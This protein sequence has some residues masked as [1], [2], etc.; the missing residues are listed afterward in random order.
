M[1]SRVDEKVNIKSMNQRKKNGFGLYGMVSWFLA[2]SKKGNRLG[3]LRNKVDKEAKRYDSKTKTFLGTTGEEMVSEKD[4]VL[5]TNA[6]MKRRARSRTRGVTR[7]RRAD[8]SDMQTHNDELEGKLLEYEYTLGDDMELDDGSIDVKVGSSEEDPLSISN[9]I[10]EFE[11]SYLTE[12]KEITDKHRKTLEEMKGELESL[13]A[14]FHSKSVALDKIVK[15][16]AHKLT[17][18]NQTNKDEKEKLPVSQGDLKLELSSPGSK[19]GGHDTSSLKVDLKETAK[20]LKRSVGDIHKKYRQAATATAAFSLATSERL[21]S[22]ED[23]DN[24]RIPFGKKNDLEKRVAE[25]ESEKSRLECELKSFKLSKNVSSSL[26]KMKDELI[27]AKNLQTMHGDIERSLRDE[28]AK[29]KENDKGGLVELLMQEKESMENMLDSLTSEWETE[30]TMLERSQ[31]LLEQKHA[32]S[33]RQIEEKHQKEKETIVVKLKSSIIEK[34]ALEKK[35]SIMQKMSEFPK[36]KGDETGGTDLG[37]DPRVLLL[38]SEAQLK[39][40]SI[41]NAN[42]RSQVSQLNDSR[43]QMAAA[44]AATRAKLEQSYAEDFRRIQD[45]RARESRRQERNLIQVRVEYEKRLLAI[46]GES[47]EAY[48]EEMKAVKDG[49]E[50]RLLQLLA[51]EKENLQQRLQHIHTS[52]SED[53]KNWENEIEMADKTAKISIAKSQVVGKRLREASEKKV[54]A[55]LEVKFGLERRRIIESHQNN[56]DLF[57]RKLERHVGLQQKIES[58]G[59]LKPEIS[60]RSNID[61]TLSS[62]E[63]KDSAKTAAIYNNIGQV[64]SEKEQIMHRRPKKQPN[65]EKTKTASN[66]STFC[67]SREEQRRQSPRKNVRSYEVMQLEFAK[68]RHKMQQDH[69]KELE[70]VVS[71]ERERAEA[72]IQ[73]LQ[74]LLKSDSSQ[75]SRALQQKLVLGEELNESGIIHLLTAEKAKNEQ[76]ARMLSNQEK[77]HR[78]EMESLLIVEKKKREASVAAE[79]AGFELQFKTKLRKMHQ[80]QQR[81]EKDREQALPLLSPN[82]GM[83]EEKSS[84]HGAPRGYSSNISPLPHEGR[85]KQLENVL[86]TMLQQRT[87]DATRSRGNPSS[88]SRQDVEIEVARERNKMAKKH[89]RDLNEIIQ[90]ERRR[91]EE[92]LQRTRELVSLVAGENCRALTEKLDSGDIKESELAQL[93]VAETVKNKQL[94]NL[95]NT[96]AAQRVSDQKR[97]ET[98][99]M[100]VAAASAAISNAELEVG[101]KLERRRMIKSHR[102]EIDKLQHQIQALIDSTSKANSEIEHHENDETRPALLKDE[103]DQL[104]SKNE[105]ILKAQLEALRADLE[106]K[107]ANE[108]FSMQQIHEKEL[109]DCIDAEKESAEERLERMRSYLESEASQTSRNLHEKLLMQGVKEVKDSDLVQL[110][111]AEKA[112]NAQLV[113]MLEKESARQRYLEHALKRQKAFHD[114]AL[115]QQK[116][117][118]KETLTKYQ[119]VQRENLISKVEKDLTKVLAEGGELVEGR[120]MRDG[121]GASTTTTTTATPTS[122]NTIIENVDSKKKTLPDYKEPSIAHQHDSAAAYPST[123]KFI[124]TES[125]GEGYH[126]IKAK[127]C[128]ILEEYRSSSIKDG[129]II[130]DDNT[131]DITISGTS[132]STLPVSDHALDFELKAEEETKVEKG[133]NRTAKERTEQIEIMYQQRINELEKQLHEKTVNNVALLSKRVSENQSTSQN[134]EAEPLQQLISAMKLQHELEIK[135]VHIEDYSRDI[136]TI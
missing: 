24:Y 55:E 22:E 7:R 20:E 60:L 108:R 41:E 31:I 61:K 127:L 115:A 71:A 85:T 78:V 37:A 93:L 104:P 77:R 26:K 102:N 19:T 69:Q 119:K 46:A 6:N 48:K 28:L 112:K 73:R 107:Y 68:E 1:S 81:E 14:K 43:R 79:R 38:E 135:V 87:N 133:V 5:S 95:L 8:S 70:E 44:E 91:S 2:S 10:D 11:V 52:H 99:S 67:E 114:K 49:D 64:E 117:Y 50:Q 32:D 66:P 106:L 110:L 130:D 47:A 34:N 100:K 105:A 33:I 123:L 126:K 56:E 90:A 13:N 39:K 97:I 82:T 74:S 124:D 16:A 53:R 18:G 23:R 109:Q 17:D 25:L 92:R 86:P 98:V 27:L 21:V 36:S 4:H 116:T 103:K 113:R 62:A 111:G 120:K 42:L 29:L 129:E 59:T 76:L 12:K 101:W 9:V 80:V 136:I 15:E 94:S 122:G 40:V 57:R 54:R 134:E 45:E 125:H 131:N 75:S 118:Y 72:E 65:I 84:S 88:L 132:N 3:R 89:A 83:K 35:C 58:S 63:E 30:R 96:E 51:D 128:E 121:G